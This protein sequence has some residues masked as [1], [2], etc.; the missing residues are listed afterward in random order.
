MN[1]TQPKLAIIGA[2]NVGTDLHQGFTKSGIY[3]PENLALISRKNF[4]DTDFRG[5]EKIILAVKP[6]DSIYALKNLAGKISKNALFVSTVS[7]LNIDIMARVLKMPYH[8]LVKM[9]LNTNASQGRVVVVYNTPSLS[10]CEEVQ[11]LFHP[12]SMLIAKKPARDI[13]KAVVSVGSGKAYHLKHLYLLCEEKN[14]DLVKL[15][16]LI[17]SEHP[18]VKDYLKNMKTAFRKIF[19]DD[20]LVD[21]SFESTIQYLR[22]SGCCTK[23][24]LIKEIDEVA[25]KGGCTRDGVDKYDSTEKATVDHFTLNIS[26]VYH[27]AKSF[28]KKIFRKYKEEFCNTTYLNNSENFLPGNLWLLD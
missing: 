2:G 8:R 17:I 12:I 25:T 11:E 26:G 19:N 20:S 1:T 10:G 14:I 16:A 3:M 27:T 9:T 6:M 7:G 18:F 28:E 23:E 4:Q 5:F 21:I 22:R 24:G 13:L 15:L